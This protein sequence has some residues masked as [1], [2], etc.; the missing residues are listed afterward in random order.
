MGYEIHLNIPEDSQR[1]RL[2]ASLAAQQQITPSQAVEK[3]IDEAVQKHPEPARRKGKSKIP[4]L[5][6][7]PI[8][9][10]DAAI[11]DEALAIVMEARL[12]RSG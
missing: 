4:G 6:H 9:E 10:E 12:E 7:E 8:S 3:I 11:V 1:G 5:P 2:I